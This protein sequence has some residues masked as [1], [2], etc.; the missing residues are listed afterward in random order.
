MEEL[1]GISVCDSPIQPKI[2]VLSGNIL[3][4]QIIMFVV[5]SYY[6]I[7]DAGCFLSFLRDFIHGTQFEVIDCILLRLLFCNFC[8]AIPVYLLLLHF[9]TRSRPQETSLSKTSKD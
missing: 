3:N 7:M 4:N 8:I 1:V 5:S 9:I 6:L 2:K